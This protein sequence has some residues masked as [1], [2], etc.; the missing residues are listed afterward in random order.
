MPALVLVRQVT[1]ITNICLLGAAKQQFNNQFLA[2]MMEIRQTNYKFYF[3]VAKLLPQEE[4]E[5]EARCLNTLILADTVIM[6]RS[7]SDTLPTRQIISR[8]E[9]LVKV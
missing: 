5:E 8:E 3:C 6:Q 9:K 2:A 7:I 1:P 4:E